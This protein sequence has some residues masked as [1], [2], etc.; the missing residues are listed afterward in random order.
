MQLFVNDDEVDNNTIKIK[1]GK[2]QITYDS[3]SEFP[4]VVEQYEYSNSIGDD[5]FSV[6]DGYRTFEKAVKV[7]GRLE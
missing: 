4:W 3:L 6:V 7:C 5:M 2:N 1:I